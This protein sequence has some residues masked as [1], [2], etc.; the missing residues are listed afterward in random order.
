MKNSQVFQ[1]DKCQSDGVI[2]MAALYEPGRAALLEESD[3]NG[4]AID[5]IPPWIFSAV[6][7]VWEI[8]WW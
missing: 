4:C 5:K 8:N 6:K 2:G 1:A 7:I 3:E